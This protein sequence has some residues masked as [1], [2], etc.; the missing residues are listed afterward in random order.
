MDFPRKALA[1]SVSNLVRPFSQSEISRFLPKSTVDE[2]QNVMGTN[3]E[4]DGSL[5][6]KL[7]LY[8]FYARKTT[9]KGSD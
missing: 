6:I 2:F 4:K 1:Y 7:V 5:D 9:K 3:W 8:C